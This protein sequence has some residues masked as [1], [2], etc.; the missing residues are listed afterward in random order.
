MASDIHTLFAAVKAH[1]DYR[2]GTIF[3]AGDLP[4]DAP[5]DPQEY[6]GL[7]SVLT[8]AGNE[9]IADQYPSE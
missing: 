7:Q 4:D 8:E 1:P 9:M 2:F 5:T 6:R 3:V